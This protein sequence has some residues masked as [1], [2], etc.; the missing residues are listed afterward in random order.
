VR[1]ER[2]ESE[3]AAPR[4]VHLSGDR[5]SIVRDTNTRQVHME[6]VEHRLGV[7]TQDAQSVLEIRTCGAHLKDHR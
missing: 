4:S 1:S 6:L 7:G 2:C 5:V 3:A